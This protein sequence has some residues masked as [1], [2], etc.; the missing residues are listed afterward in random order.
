[1]SF[2]VETIVGAAI[3]L[4]IN[5]LMSSELLN[6]AREEQLQT[7]VRKWIRSLIPAW[8]TSF[9]PRNLEFHS[10]MKSEFEEITARFE[11]LLKQKGDLAPNVHV[12]RRP[13]K[14]QKRFPTT[15]LVEESDLSFS[16]LVNLVLDSCKKCKKLPGLG[17]LP[18]LKN[19]TIMSMNE[20]ESV[21]S[22]FYSSHADASPSSLLSPFPSL[23][24]LRFENM[25]KWLDWSLPDT[26][27]AKLISLE[28]VG[29][30]LLEFPI[31]RLN[32]TASH[33]QSLVLRGCS[34]AI[35]RERNIEHASLKSLYIGGISGLSS[36]PDEFLLPNVEKLTVSDCS[37]LE[38]LSNGLHMLASLEELW[39]WNCAKLAYLEL[40]LMPRI[41]ENQDCDV[42]RCLTEGSNSTSLALSGLGHKVLSI[43]GCPSL[44]SISGN[45]WFR[46]IENLQITDCDS[47]ESFPSRQLSTTLKSLSIHNCPKLESVSE[48]MLIEST[49]L[50]NLCFVRYLKLKSLPEC[51][52]T[53][54]DLT[55][56]YVINCEGIETFPDTGLPP[57]LQR[58]VILGCRNLRSLPNNM[59]DLTSLHN[60]TI[61]NCPLLATA[62]ATDRPSSHALETGDPWMSTASPK[63]LK[64]EEGEEARSDCLLLMSE[65]LMEKQ[66]VDCD[67]LS[68]IPG[69]GIQESIGIKGCGC[70][71]PKSAKLYQRIYR[72]GG[73]MKNQTCSF[74]LWS[75]PNFHKS[76]DEK[77]LCWILS[78]IYCAI[79][80]V[81]GFTMPRSFHPPKPASKSACK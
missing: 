62:L 51:L 18:S 16:G 46:N 39:I 48:E 63:V 4:L 30:P 73:S 9:A 76:L 12:S 17:Q 33:L 11:Q 70:D 52:H 7:A 26:S 19:L 65:C 22:E 32:S 74:C 61:S 42:L 57:N 23:E 54:T 47:L 69:F 31:S 43:Y 72:L 34:D 14:K 50:H 81:S 64:L 20:V 2:V 68:V 13:N 38:R 53:L 45:Q 60:L 24:C 15:S 55:S 80:D 27:F 49:S 41:L 66:G 10:N 29:C 1:M 75:S 44:T 5:K 8:F 40:P 36:L 78:L 25:T 21:G 67:K 35:I 58:L 28:I 6:F 71:A 56:L 77:A 79:E 37:E 3:E 59:D